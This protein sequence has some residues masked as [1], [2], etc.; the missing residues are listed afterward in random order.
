[1]ENTC[2]IEGCDGK[3]WSRGLCTKHYAAWR[4]DGKKVEIR[5]ARTKEVRICEQC[6]GPIPPERRA[7]VMFCSSQC[8]RR[9]QYDKEKSSPEPKQNPPCSVDGCES[10][11]LAKKLCSKHYNRLRDKG[12]LDDVRQN[13][14][15]A[16]STEGCDRPTV[17]R[18]LCDMHYRVVLA[19]EKRHARL[20][21]LATRTC[22]HCGGSMGDRRA[23]SMFCSADC[24]RAERTASGAGAKAALKSYFSTRYGLTAEQ[25]EEMAAGGCQI[26]GTF[27]WGGRHNRPNVDHCHTTG[28][29]RGA[30]CTQCNYGLGQFKDDPALLRKAADYLTP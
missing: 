4:R 7:N 12:S 20:P 30:L 3:H 19:A 1:M 23:A 26:C 10:A 18:G 8:K 27:E 15:G 13:H 17:G 9:A 22:M 21:I 16:C 24:K 2:S 28:R 29:V 5:A 14:R 6:G 25:V 11:Q